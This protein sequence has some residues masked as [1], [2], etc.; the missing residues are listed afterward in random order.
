M[1]SFF[2]VF[3]SKPPPSPPVRKAPTLNIQPEYPQLYNDGN[4]INRGGKSLRHSRKHKRKTHR[5][6]R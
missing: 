4:Y 5:R 2:S 6:R 1:G 3:S